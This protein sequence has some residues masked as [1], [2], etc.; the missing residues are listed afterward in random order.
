M[1]ALA[2]LGQ[3]AFGGIGTGQLLIYAVVI[4]AC[5]GIVFL[6]MGHFGVRVPPVVMNIF[7]IVLIA[8][9]AIVAIR[10]VLSM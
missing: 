1:N 2:L 5:L 7:W 4:A 8:F 6:A 10:L 9:V 3:V